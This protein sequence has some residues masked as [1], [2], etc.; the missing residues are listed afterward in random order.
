MEPPG[1]A[2]QRQADLVSLDLKALQQ[3]LRRAV[4]DAGTIAMAA[5][6]RGG[7]VWEKGPGQVLTETDLAVDRA[8]HE[9]LCSILD[10]AA[11]LSEETADDGLRLER[12]HVWVVDPIDGTR[13]FAKGRPE[14]TISVALVEEG[15]SVLACLLNPA[16]GECFEARTGGGATLNEQPLSMGEPADARQARI[17]LSSS[18]R[19]IRQFDAFFPEAR[20]STIGSLAYKMALVA[21]GRFDAY[22]SWRSSHDW[23]IAAALLI[24]EEAGGRASDRSGATLALNQPE[25]RHRGLIA[26]SPA[27]HDELAQISRR[28]LAAAEMPDPGLPAMAAPR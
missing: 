5:F 8:L 10:S 6:G 7:K 12:R 27:L 24:L 16:T 3:E 1:L 2:R 11:W 4:L 21:A 28:Q 19:K 25:P 15:R 23:D 18:E 14:F 26:A 20:V 9:S 22:F 13:S 17:V